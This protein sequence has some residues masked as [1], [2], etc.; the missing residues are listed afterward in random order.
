G[1]GR[2]PGEDRTS[3]PN[4][5]AGHPPI[6]G[7][8]SRAPVGPVEGA[9][10]FEAP[11]SWEALPAGGMRKAAFQ[12]GDQEEGA[13]VTLID[14]PVD[15]GPMITDP[16]QNVNRWRIEVGLPKVAKDQ[17]GDVVE[18]IEIDGKPAT[19][20]VLVPDPEVL[21]QSK[22]DRATLGAMLV[23]EERIWFIKM[24]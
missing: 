23:H 3:E 1:A 15:A 8:A 13:L 10:S 16:Y 19:Y 6:G 4:L 18:E 21:E 11:D 20:V 17:L 9:P 2:P 7:E 14:F 22:L 24:T 12:V 5:P